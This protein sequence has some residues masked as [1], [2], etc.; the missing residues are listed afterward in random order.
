MARNGASNGGRGMKRTLQ[1]NIRLSLEEEDRLDLLSE[2]YGVT[3]AA[4]I[5]LLLKRESDA[6]ANGRPLAINSFADALLGAAQ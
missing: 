5:R 1:I 4:V 6:L 2:H 3:C